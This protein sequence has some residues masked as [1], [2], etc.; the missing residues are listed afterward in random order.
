MDREPRD[1]H[2]LIDNYNSRGGRKKVRSEPGHGLKGS[3]EFVGTGEN[4]NDLVTY[5]TRGSWWNPFLY[6]TDDY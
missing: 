5:W 6:S 3:K 4:R 1:G 2:W